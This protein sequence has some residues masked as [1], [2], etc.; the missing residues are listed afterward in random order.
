[1][2]VVVLAAVGGVFFLVT[3]LLSVIV[4][5]NRR[6]GQVNRSTN[7]AKDVTVNSYEQEDVDNDEKTDS[8]MTQ[9]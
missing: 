8:Q 5:R 6:R 9:M 7:I 4:Y 2:L 3:I 1:V